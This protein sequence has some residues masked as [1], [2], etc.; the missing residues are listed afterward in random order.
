MVKRN[1][2]FLYPLSLGIISGIIISLLDFNLTS[3]KNILPILSSTVSI[4]SI[5][6]GFLAT[7][8]SVL[9]SLTNTK[10]MER[11]RNAEANETL[12][13]YIKEAIIIGLIF[14]VYSLIL[15][16][17]DGYKGKV[18]NLLLAFYVLFLTYFISATYRIFHI[19]LNI[20]TSVL[21]SPPVQ[22]VKDEE[23]F[24]TNSS[25]IFRE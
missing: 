24:K 4:T 2:E 14:A 17:F 11:I 21:N 8:V 13:W 25:N 12:S 19:I 7:M 15:H 23:S 18:S 16:M 1:I 9:I 6:I 5:I 3:I 22:A 20:L 10:V